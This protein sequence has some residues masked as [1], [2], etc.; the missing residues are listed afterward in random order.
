M[1]RRIKPLIGLK[2]LIAPLIVCVDG[3]DINGYGNGSTHNVVLVKI[4]G[5]PEI[6]ET[7]P[8]GCITHVLDLKSNVGVT[9]INGIYLSD[10][11]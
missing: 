2:V 11:E 4:N 8:D 1:D 9:L 7:A 6:L 5:P 10:V 3:V